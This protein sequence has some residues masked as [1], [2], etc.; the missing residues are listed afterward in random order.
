MTKPKIISLGYAVPKWCYGQE[1]IFRELGYPKHFWRIFRDAQI[2][3]RHF[4]VPLPQIRKLT[5]QEQQEEYIK[6]ALE[7]AKRAILQCL[8]GRPTEQ[9]GLVTWST[10]TGFPPGPVIPHYFTNEFHSTDDIEINN[11]SSQGCEAAF[12]GLRRCHDYT[13]VTGRPSL[14]IA[15]ELCCL[16]YYPEVIG[17]DPENDYELLRS[18]SLFADGCSCALIGFD[19]DSKHPE[20]RDFATVL[21]T[22]YKDDLGYIWKNGRLRVRLS[23]RVPDIAAELAGRV[24]HKIL[25]RHCLDIQDIRYWVIHPPGAIVLDKIRD[26]LKIEED[27]LK[28]SRQALREYG[29]TSSSAVGIVGKLLINQEPDPSG[30]LM[31]VNV[32]P[33]M[34]S[35]ATLLRFGG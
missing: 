2:D 10:C 5:F 3:K 27:K 14:A 23:K 34:V 21:D 24:V 16:T 13:I 9:I 6:Q 28:Y 35:N 1:L 30:Y 22:R 26:G 31:M 12:P 7:L 29:N 33:G 11:L 18:N 15:C 4:C 20:I 32:G 8:D 19:N 25:S 17:A